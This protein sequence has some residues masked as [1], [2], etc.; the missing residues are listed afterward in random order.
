MTF[1]ISKTNDNTRLEVG[2]MDLKIAQLRKLKG[3]SQQQL[4]D[5]LGVTFQSV[6]KWETKTTLPDITLLPLIA[7]F[8]QVSVD[9]VLGLVPIHSAPYIPRDTDDREKWKNREHVMKNDRQFFWNDDYLAFLV[10]EVWKVN[11]PI[12]MLEM[13]CC[14]GEFGKRLMALLPK[15]STYTGVDSEYLIGQAKKNFSDVEYETTLISSDIYSF[16]QPNQYDLCICQCALRHMNHPLE[17]LRIM[18]DSVKKNGL[19]VT[20]ELNR[21]IENVGLY[22]DGV[23]YEHMCTAFDWRKLWKKEL[24]SEGRDYAIGFRAPF[25]MQQ[26]GLHDV[27]T[28][29][30]DKASFVS[31]TKKEYEKLV[32][33]LKAFRGWEHESNEKMEESSIDFFMSRGYNRS[34]VNQL[35]DFQNE[36][37]RRIQTSNEISFLLVFGQIIAYGRK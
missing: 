13:C 5:F 32:A 14:D 15:G 25:Y 36:M 29:L 26:I 1:D 2:V 11:Q 27:D 10:K 34:E 9:E 7:E 12:H 37:A 24:L 28:R 16:T 21:E 3:I 6:S 35:H 18:K 20:V 19:V 8:F 17:I 23:D 33:G 4:A 22:I 31:P 30:N